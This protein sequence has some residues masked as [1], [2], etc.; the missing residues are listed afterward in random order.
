MDNKPMTSSTAD[1]RK[2]QE[3]SALVDEVRRLQSRLAAKQ[4][5]IHS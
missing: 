4:Q 5:S 1:P 3:L 2:E